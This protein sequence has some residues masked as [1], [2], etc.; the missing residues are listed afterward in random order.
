MP[1]LSSPLSLFRFI[2]L[3]ANDLLIRFFFLYLFN[4]LEHGGF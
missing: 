4:Y 3:I 1:L 2:T